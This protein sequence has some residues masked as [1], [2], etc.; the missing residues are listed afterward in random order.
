MAN[1]PPPGC[2]VKRQVW[3]HL[4]TPLRKSSMQ[5][6]NT[7]KNVTVQEVTRVDLQG[8]QTGGAVLPRGSLSAEPN[9][10]ACRERAEECRASDARDL[11]GITG[12]ATSAS[13]SADSKH[14]QRRQ[15]SAARTY[16]EKVPTGAR[17][18]PPP[19]W[20]E[21]EDEAE[22][23]WTDVTRT[24]SFLEGALNDPDGGAA[25]KFYLSQTNNFQNTFQKNND[26]GIDA[27]LDEID[28]LR[29]EAR[30]AYCRS[31]SVGEGSRWSTT[32]SMLDEIMGLGDHEIDDD[33]ICRTVYYTVAAV[34][35]TN[36]R[37]APERA[38]APR[39]QPKTQS[40]QQNK[41]R[42]HLKTRSE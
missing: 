38:S 24:L 37:G 11:A 17:V 2:R 22:K 16:T 23:N 35:A 28:D 21:L 20:K 19:D 27:I 41:P 39:K 33:I 4:K 10:S 1:P 36:D 31:L 32:S 14:T 6:T 3:G 26:A 42:K 13:E 40:E 34:N 29:D 7:E 18:G 15:A 9:S 5:Y 25:A 30:E 12:Y 8:R